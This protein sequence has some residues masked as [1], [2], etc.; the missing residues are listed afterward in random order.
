[1]IKKFLFGFLIIIITAGIF[2]G[3]VY[4]YMNDKLQKERAQSSKDKEDLQKQI[5]ELNANFNLAKSQDDK[6]SPTMV[7][8]TGPKRGLKQWKFKFSKKMN[9]ETLKVGNIN[10]YIYDATVVSEN[11]TT[12]KKDLDNSQFYSIDYN[13]EDSSLLIMIKDINAFTCSACMWELEFTSQIKDIYG[14]SLTPKII[15]F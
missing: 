10:M 2:G 11:Q 13:G 9:K 5:V 6:K 14:N 7:A 8:Q 4:F 12:K 3:S 1:M 15:S